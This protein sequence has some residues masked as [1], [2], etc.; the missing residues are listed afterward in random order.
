MRRAY[1]KKLYNTHCYG[2]QQ[3]TG[4][5]GQLLMIIEGMIA[6]RATNQTL[7]QPV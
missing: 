2:M 4:V 7:G 3:H 1:E 6:V 5:L